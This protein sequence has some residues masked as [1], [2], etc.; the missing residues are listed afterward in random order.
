MDKVKATTPGQWLVSVLR[1]FGKRR[2]HQPAHQPAIREPAVTVK[3][4]PN[5]STVTFFL[6]EEG[7]GCIQLAPGTRCTYLDGPIEVEISGV[8]LRFFKL[9]HGDLVGYVN[10]RCVDAPHLAAQPAA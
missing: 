9:E 2:H 7:A 1:P 8:T 5:Q 10:V 4:H 3:A 6:D